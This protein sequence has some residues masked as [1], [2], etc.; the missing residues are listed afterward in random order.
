MRVCLIGAPV[1]PLFAGT[2][3]PAADGWGHRGVLPDGHGWF[4]QLDRHAGSNGEA[5][6]D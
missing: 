6:N 2:A 3:Q 5:R 1:A 4:H